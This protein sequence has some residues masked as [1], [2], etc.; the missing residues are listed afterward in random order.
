M[1]FGLRPLND[2]IP[3]PDVFELSLFGCGIGESAALHL[4]GGE[5]AIVDSCR[6]A[7]DENPMPLQYLAE[8]GVDADAAVRLVLLTHWHDDHV[9]GAA[10]IVAACGAARVAFSGAMASDEFLTILELYSESGRIVDRRTSGVYELGRISQVIKDRV[11][12]GAARNTTRAAVRA[13]ADTVLYRREDCSV[14]AI[15]PSPGSIHVAHQELGSALR[16]LVESP[17]QALVVPPPHRNDY[18]VALWIK[19]RD[20]RVLM[21]GDLEVSAD[22]GRGWAAAMQCVHFPDGNAQI[23]KIAHHG[24]PN[25]DDPVVWANHVD[26]NEPTAVLTSYTRGSTPRPSREDLARIKDR[27]SGVY[28]TTLPSKASPRRDGAVERELASVVRSRKVLGRTAGQ[29]RVR[30]QIGGRGSNV[31]VRGAALRA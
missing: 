30:W 15:A 28:Y 7:S 12:A 1:V 22:L 2:P 25:G 31:E 4:G 9:D 29:V 5:W 6:R 10:D 11:G 8:I 16:A 14:I 13:Q 24:S 17:A 23:V 26:Q 19:W 18:S 27:T 20:L 21:G 3:S